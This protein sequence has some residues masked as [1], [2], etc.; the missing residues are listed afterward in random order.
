MRAVTVSALLELYAIS[1]RI[2]N[3]MTCLPRLGEA[4][5]RSQSM[6]GNALL[7]NFKEVLHV[8]RLPLQKPPRPLPKN[9]PQMIS[10]SP[11]QTNAR[12]VQKNRT[13]RLAMTRQVITGGQVN[14]LGTPSV[15]MR[16]I[17]IQNLA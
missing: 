17:M 4:V 3:A 16:K 8:T 15:G 13:T 2:Q 1:A 12:K 7:A 6:E 5:G 14:L 9:T 11:R 10:S